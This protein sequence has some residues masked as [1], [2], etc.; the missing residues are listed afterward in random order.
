VKVAGRAVPAGVVVGGPDG[1]AFRADL[2]EVVLT[3]LT[4]DGT[5]LRIE[6]WRPGIGLR[7]I[8]RA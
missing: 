7:R 3:G 1:E 6:S 5:K 4:E 2:D 8:E